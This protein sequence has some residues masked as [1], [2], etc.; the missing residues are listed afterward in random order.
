MPIGHLLNQTVEIQRN[1]RTSDGAG[2]FADLYVTM[3]MVPSRRRPATVREASV[4]G[5]VRADISDVFYFEAGTSMAVQ[6]RLVLDGE[7]WE[8]VGV[9]HPSADHHLEVLAARS[10]TGAK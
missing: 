6:D 7:S 9:K 2:G 8:V 4:A 10:Q 3:V 1:Q 5:Q